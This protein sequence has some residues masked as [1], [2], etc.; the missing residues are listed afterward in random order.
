[1]QSA[2]NKRDVTWRL[3]DILKPP[4]NL[5][6]VWLILPFALTFLCF[7]L[8]P[9]RSWDYWWHITMGRLIDHYQAVPAANR[10]LYTM[11]PKAPS[12]IQP[13]MSQWMLF[14]LHDVG[15]LQL[16]LLARNFLAASVFG[17]VGVAASR[18]TRSPM[19]GALVTMVGLLLAFQFIGARTHM[20]VWP[21]F[22]LLLWVG[23]Q[24]RRRRFPLAL[25]AL[26]PAVAALWANLHGSFFLVAAI[27]LAF[28]GAAVADRWVGARQFSAVRVGVWI[29][30]VLASAAAPML[31]PRGAQ[32]YG[33]I[34][35]LMSNHE[36]HATVT[37]WMPTS[38]NNPVGIGA[39]F[40]AVLVAGAVLFWR[41]RRQ[42]DPA[43]VLLFLGFGLV[44]A[45]GARG[46]MWFGIVVPVTMA[47]YLAKAPAQAS[48]KAAEAPGC[49][50][51]VVH[52]LLALGLLTASCLLQP[53]TV[54]Q[55]DVVT[56][57]PPI[58]VRTI[59]PMAGLV[60]ADT[61][62]VEAEILSKYPMGMRLFHDQRYAGY[63]MYHLT[64]LHPAPIVFV[65]QRIELPPARIWRLYDLINST[66]AWKGIFHQYEV[67]AAVLSK[68]KQPKLVER[69]RAD[70]LWTL[71]YEDDYN[72]LFVVNK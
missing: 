16:A 72:A 58:P 1:M 32:I 66:T 8:L 45:L 9:L 27:A 33:Y 69:M 13:W 37:E 41:N 51:S 4:Y 15:G 61:P 39:F 21:L 53:G 18:R 28:A 40:Y 12:F 44:A 43:D 46:L 14:W 19:R 70:S 48:T 10:Y 5:D 65:D 67:R 11:D 49:M 7:G 52:V 57:Y 54:F 55:R 24:V 71:A 56:K 17:F 34:A 64:K 42:F 25:V 68:K 63:L 60:P 30:G 59:P 2:P 31:N 47:P 50:T 29:G 62:V 23:Y 26:F 38:F 22:G 6:L 36:I 3:R 35:D 20:F